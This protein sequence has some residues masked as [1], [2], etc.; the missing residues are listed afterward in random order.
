M[1]S[2]RLAVC[3]MDCLSRIV[4][5]LPRSMPGRSHQIIGNPRFYG[6]DDVIVPRNNLVA[7]N[8]PNAVFSFKMS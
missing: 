8:T 2:L 7:Q 1:I 5:T 6:F 3:I 4:G